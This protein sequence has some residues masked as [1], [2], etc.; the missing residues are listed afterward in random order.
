[1]GITLF[2]VYTLREI[3]GCRVRS[4]LLYRGRPPRA[5]GRGALYIF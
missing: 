3:K 5:E 1:M 2:Y 4:S